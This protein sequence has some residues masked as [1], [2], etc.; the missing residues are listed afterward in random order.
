MAALALKVKNKNGQH[1]LKDLTSDSTVGELKIFL[2]SLS[3]VSIDRI[4]VLCGYPPKALDI[5]NDN[6]TLNDIGLK[7]GETL[8][9]EEKNGVQD[10]S[11][12][13]TRLTS[14]ENGVASH[15]TMAPCRPGILMKKVVP[16]DN[17]CL[18]TSIGK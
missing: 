8:I 10:T 1:I 6:Q 12:Q 13:L 15:D 5:S 17:S 18:F 7:S 3:D 4:Y 14:V 2:S 9:L 16:P 11:V